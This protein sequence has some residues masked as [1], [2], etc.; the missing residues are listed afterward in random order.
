MSVSA[1]LTDLLT[2]FIVEVMK[3]KPG[4]IVDFAANYF[5]LLKEKKNK[6][7]D[8][9]KKMEKQ[10]IDS[11]ND[12]DYFFGSS[13]GAQCSQPSTSQTRILPLMKSQ[14]L[15][16]RRNSIA[17]EPFDTFD[18]ALH[19]EETHYFKP[20]EVRNRLKKIVKAIFIFKSCSCD[21]LEKLI[22]AMYERKVY[23]GETI[24]RQGEQGENFYVV[25]QGKFDVVFEVDDCKQNIGRVESPGSFGELALMYNCP[26]S[27]SVIAKEDGV[28]WVLDRLTF[29]RILF[30]TTEK[31]RSHYEQLLEIMPILSLLNAYERAVLADALETRVFEDGHCVIQEG[32]IAECMYFIEEGR[33]SISVQEDQDEDRN[34]IAY[35]EKGE[36]FG[37]LALVY[38]TRRIASVF[39]EGQ[40]TCACLDINAFERLLGPCKDLMKRN[41]EKYENQ[42]KLLGIRELNH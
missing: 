7:R 30:K 37:E 11:K 42:R 36:Y 21:Q 8:D 23:T 12:G 40:V 31:K 29:R 25:D 26:R 16:Q 19:R 24:I 34:I 15:L 3:E 41:A 39:A 18:S 14:R 20:E 33:V 10:E 1:E 32:D 13:F 38:K 28:V 4:D 2:D 27:A 5:S 6:V 17:G 22:N 9:E 35:A